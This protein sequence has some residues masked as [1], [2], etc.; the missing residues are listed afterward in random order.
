MLLF[1]QFPPGNS[2]VVVTARNPQEER[3]LCV[4]ITALNNNEAT[5]DWIQ[6][7]FKTRCIDL[8]PDQSCG[9]ACTLVRYSEALLQCIKKMFPGEGNA[10][11]RKQKAVMMR[12]QTRDLENVKLSPPELPSSPRTPS[13]AKPQFTPSADSTSSTTRP[14]KR[15]WDTPLSGAEM[16]QDHTHRGAARGYKENI[17]KNVEKCL[18]GTSS[19]GNNIP[20]SLFKSLEKR[21]RISWECCHNEGQSACKLIKVECIGAH[22]PCYHEGESEFEAKQLGA[23]ISAKCLWYV[24][25]RKLENFQRRYLA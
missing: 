2:R 3:V 21:P 24:L 17:R 4:D 9:F 15:K 13:P 19:I 5:H 10:L 7:E 23:I 12:M 22:L 18:L 25:P 20:Q 6:K 8:Q 14:I 1:K 16:Q 11:A